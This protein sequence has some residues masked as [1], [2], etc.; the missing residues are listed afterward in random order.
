MEFAT[1]IFLDTISS[2]IFLSY[3]I[4][5]FRNS[6]NRLI[7]NFAF[8]NL[9][10][11]VFSIGKIGELLASSIES[12]FSMIIIQCFGITFLSV[13]LFCFA[14][15]FRYN[16][17]PGINKIGYISIIPFA[18]LFLV[19]T[20]NVHHLYYKK[21]ELLLYKEHFV[22]SSFKGFFY[23]IFLI[24]LYSMLIFSIYA[25]FFAYKKNMCNFKKQSKLI[26]IGLL[27][28][29]VF[30][31]P[32]LIDS[33]EIN[34]ALLGFLFMTCFSFKA[35][36]QYHF[37]DLKETIREYYLDKITEGIFVI[38]TSNRIID[39][40]REASILLPFLNSNYLG[41]LISDYEVGKKVIEVNNS[42]FFEIQVEF[43]EIVKIYEFRKM[44][45]VSKRKTIAYAYIFSDKTSI[46]NLVSNLYSLASQDFLTGIN[47]RMN[48]LK[49]AESE[50][51]RI[52]RYKGEFSIVMIDIDYFKRINDTYGH[53]VGDEVLKGL[54][55]LI[56]NNLRITDIFA[57]L[58]GEEFCILF[59]ET[60]I[61]SGKKKCEKIRSLIEENPIIVND[62]E[63]N[64]TISVGMTYYNNE[65]T[66][67]PIEIIIDLADRAM[68]T[69]KRLGRNMVM[70]NHFSLRY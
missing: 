28:P 63:I 50:L 68:Y 4:Y 13:F 18:S 20:N 45:I 17:Y 64:I 16:K 32:F 40:N 70:Y 69:A 14:Y 57:R 31:I 30:S 49:L 43:R 60:S 26:L 56:K 35:L 15:K 8:M 36:F 59:P 3:S 24:N 66:E 5:S 38:D 11:F 23:Y 21:I 55:N 46:K 12:V 39:F 65:M 58:G 48:F 7:L 54:T 37:L 33:Y 1:L 47:N 25:L 44:P 62:L 41:N 19:I 29:L 6:S 67:V 42:S 10:M 51:N 9:A 22:L 2:F 61:N 27:F 52:K 34:L 53:R